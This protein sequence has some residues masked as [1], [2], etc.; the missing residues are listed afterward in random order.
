M[1]VHDVHIYRKGKYIRTERN[2]PIGIGRVVD[3]EGEPSDY[4]FVKKTKSSPVLP[5]NP[6]GFPEGSEL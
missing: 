6:V 2:V 3:I 4:T 5:A 1:E